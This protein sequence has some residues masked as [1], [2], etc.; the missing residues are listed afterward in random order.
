MTT[1][2]SLTLSNWGP[3]GEN[4]PLQITIRDSNDISPFALAVFRGHASLA[5]VIL[6][7]AQAQY[8]PRDT[9]ETR[10]RYAIDSDSDDKSDEEDQL[11]IQSELVDEKFTIAD[12][13][14]LAGTIK[15]KTSALEMLSWSTQIWRFSDKPEPEAKLDLFLASKSEIAQSSRWEN[16]R[17]PRANF[18]RAY[19][20]HVLLSRSLL[21]YAI[22]KESK[23]LVK[24]LLQC[25]SD[26]VLT[27]NS[28]D[29][30]QFTIEARDWIFAIE[31]GNPQILAELIKGTGAG[32]P[33]EY[34]AKQTGVEEDEKPKVSRHSSTRLPVS[35]S[36]SVLPRTE[37]TWQSA[38]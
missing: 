4:I 30:K 10:M 23:D 2:K 27:E 29:Q 5:K 9:T 19:N 21:H 34:L 35:D 7:I 25:G 20:E 11:N 6:D 31:R 18:D 13:G 1:V 37:V 24:F 26:S 8:Q 38:E 28:L 3:S 22:A 14:A 33:L 32:M 15:S 36:T 16:D 17:N 12:I